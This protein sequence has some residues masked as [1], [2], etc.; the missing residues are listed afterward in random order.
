MEWLILR[1]N[2]EGKGVGCAESS[3]DM[4]A[5]VAVG[6]DLVAKGF[7]GVEE[8]QLRAFAGGVALPFDDL[9]QG[10]AVIGTDDKGV[11]GR[12]PLL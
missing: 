8:A 5:G 12:L 1:Y 4:D 2:A 3:R 9:R 6:G 11:E 10:V 7:A